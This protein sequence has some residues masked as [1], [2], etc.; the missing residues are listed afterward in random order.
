MDGVGI[1]PRDDWDAVHRAH[2][3]TLDRLAGEGLFRSLVAHGTAVGL[4]SDGDMGNSEVCHNALGAGKIYDQGAKLVENSIADGS[5][6]ASETWRW[7]IEPCVGSD[8]ALHLIGLL[9][10]GNVHSHERHLH[11]ILEQAAGSGVRTIFVHAL[12]DGRDVPGQSAEIYLERLEALLGRLREAHGGDFAIA[13][14]GGRMTI[15][16]DRYEADWPMVAAGWKTHVHHEGP[17]FPSAMTALRHF[18][19]EDPR[20]IDQFLPAFVVDGAGRGRAI[21][22]GDGVLLFNFRGD[23]AIELCRAFEEERFQPF[24]RGARPDVRF[25]GMTLYDGDA[26]IPGRFL[27]PPPAIDFTLSEHLVAQRCRQFAVSETQKFGHVTYFWNGNRSGKFDEGLET[28]L[29]I[30]SDNVPFEQR[31]WMQAAQITDATLAAMQRGE[32]FI[33]LNYP[34]GD[35]VGHS[36]SVDASIVSVEAVDLGLSRLVEAAQR[37]GYRL[38]VLADHGNADDMAQR[39]KDGSPKRDEQGRVIPRTSHSLNPVPCT[40]YPAI[41]LAWAPGIEQAGLGHVA[42][43]LLDL[44]GLPADDR[45]LPSLIRRS[46]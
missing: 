9:S 20:R 13:S 35:M 45:F 40:I 31:P 39:N 23:R 7:L 37:H 25:A 15:T 8:R 18:R 33:R 46:G 10:D 2:T 16:M 22:D 27:V 11:R 38:M 17:R 41:E 30:P 24:D 3:P 14:G 1:G 6:F 34:N 4:P 43:T 36:G 21:Q 42:A 5:A 26:Q 29:E 44:L 19:E 32:S 12:L 28:Y